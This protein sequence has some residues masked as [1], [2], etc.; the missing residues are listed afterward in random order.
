MPHVRPLTVAILCVLLAVPRAAVGQEGEGEHVRSA[1]RALNIGVRTAGLSLGNSHRWNGLRFNVVDRDVER[2][3]GLNVTFW[4]PVHNEDAVYNGLSIGLVPGGGTFRGLTVGLGAAVADG[5]MSGINIGGLALV[6]GGALRG[7]NI[8]G[9]ATVADRDLAGI[10]IAGL[11]TVAEGD[12]LGINVGGLGAV[13][14][15]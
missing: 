10:N 7:V 2:I 11:G 9:L 8:A 14:Q 1:G 4:R 15:G 5:E 12:M 6:S 13:A 3:N